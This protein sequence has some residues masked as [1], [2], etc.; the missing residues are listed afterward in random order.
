MK[1]SYI[2][3]SFLLVSIVAFAQRPLPIQ[4]TPT[5]VA[6]LANY[7]RPTYPRSIFTSPPNGAVRTMAEWEEV[8]AL[9]ITWT[10]YQAI[11]REIVRHAK[12]EVDVIIICND[13]VSVKSYLANYNITNQNV[14]FIQKA[15]N[16]IWIRDYGQHSVYLND[17][18][19][20]VLVDWIYNRPRPADDLIPRWVADKTNLDLYATTQSPTDLVNTGGNF[21]SDGLGRGFAS[22]LILDENKPGN[23]YGV[24]SKT[25]A[26]IDTIMKHFMGI[27]P[28]IK[29]QT[30]PYDNIHHIDMHMKLL[31][32]ET[33]LIGEYPQGVA[34]GPQIEANIN[35][36]KN[37]YL[38]SFGTPF[39]FVRIQMPPDGTN[40]YPNQ[41]GD[42]RTY[43]NSVFINKLVLVPIYDP[44]YDFPALEIYRKN[45]PGYKVVGINCNSIIQNLGA[46]HCI[47]KS[48]GVTNPLRI[49]HQPIRD[50]VAVASNYTI[51]GLIQHRSGIANANIYY[52]TDTTQIYQTTPMS[53]VS[54]DTWQGFIPTQSDGSEVFYYIEATA[55]SGKTQNRPMSAPQG[56]WNFRIDQFVS[57]AQPKNVSIAMAKVFPNPAADYVIAPIIIDKPIMATIQLLDIT[58]KVAQTV[59]EGK[60]NRSYNQNI[61]VSQLSKGIYFLTL[62]TV[63]GIQTQKIIVD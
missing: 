14:S 33:I 57:T 52:T 40:R 59:F 49:V 55:N 46:L 7:E 51:E 48:V 34:D 28:Y 50:T 21:M 30:L 63:E 37:N 54:G 18:D 16:S 10:G 45:L 62:R 25:E 29:M 42:Y 43:T 19:S 26:Q 53:F 11:L 22:S 6:A 47:T 13:S 60:V 2:L 27:E 23:P 17:V 3:F 8:Q 58:G 36:I 4:L 39:R 31:D 9:T 35:Y 32:E 61:D 24:S 1:K 41:G 12:E 56:F 38:S 44:T 5:E 15:Y 20:L